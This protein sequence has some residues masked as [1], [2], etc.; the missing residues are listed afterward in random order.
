MLKLCLPRTTL[1]RSQLAGSNLRIIPS[2]RLLSYS[3]PSPFPSNSPR[4]TRCLTVPS[5]T[6]FI[7]RTL[8]QFLVPHRTLKTASTDNGSSWRDLKRLTVLIKKDIKLLV[9]AI[10]LLTISCSIGMAIPK[11]IGTILDTLR[12]NYENLTS[13]S[14]IKILNIPLS[15]FLM[16][17]G[18]TLIFGCFANFGRVVI[19]RIISE[20]LVSRLRSQ[21]VKNIIHKD[22]EFFDTFKVGDLMSRV[23]NDAFVVS[24]S[25]TH[26]VA[27]GVRSGF[28]GIFGIGLMLTL[29]RELTGA[30]FA[31][32]PPIIWCTSVFGKQIRMNSKKLQ[33]VTGDLTRV[34]EEQ[35]NGIR[36]VQGFVAERNEI[37][38]FNN[39]LREIFQVGKESAFINGKFFTSAS[40]IGDLGFLIVLTYGSYLVMH[41]S[42]SIG[43]LT[44]FML[45]TEYTGN[46]IFGLSSFYSELMQGVGAASRIFEINDKEPKIKS[47]TGEA[48]FKPLN[49][50]GGCEIEF[51]NVSFFYPTRPTN[52]IFKNLNFKVPAGSNVCIVGPSGRGKSTIASLLLHHYNAVSGQILIDGQDIATLNTKSLRRK[53]GIVQQEPILMSGTIRDN[54]TYGLTEEP[55][56]EEIR[57]VAKQCFCHNFITK[58]PDTYD[59]TIGS[60]SSGTSLSGGQKQRIAIARALIKKPNILILDEAT[61]A[62]DVE[63]EGAINYTFGQI[64]KSKSM[65]IVSI[66]HRLST[67]RRFEDVIVLGNDGS[68]VE[69]GKFKELYDNPT[70]ELSKLLNE[71][72]STK[73]ATP[74]PVNPPPFIDLQT[75]PEEKK[76]A[77]NASE[78]N[79]AKLDD[80][81][82]DVSVPDNM[83]S[84]DD[85]LKEAVNEGGPIKITP[86]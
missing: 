39:V 42:M 36:T 8:P 79:G 66:A 9:L 16:G 17:V 11:I 61:S 26:K 4:P 1:L 74:Q 68:V 13:L 41:G 55:S 83:T 84:S 65:T 14:Q 37:K 15:T 27:D 53:I 77:D 59:T 56:K 73:E 32:L 33:D 30:L 35:F 23:G 81:K 24:R 2:I 21:V 12:N 18:I 72:S 70:S 6:N 76:E 82:E 45:Y 78:E 20:R 64:M 29:S 43:D 71:K 69:M 52:Q 46:A 51:K 40:L 10:V 57:L 22:L 58:F 38:R 31:I 5:R 47:T 62:L 85:S 60:G 25:I 80:S 34:T 7:P 28:I 19:L 44:A 67:I 75:N 63:S 3:R 54:I 86:R 50:V 49:E 48:K